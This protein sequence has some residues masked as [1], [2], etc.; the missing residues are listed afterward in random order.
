M[1]TIIDMIVTDPS[2]DPALRCILSSQQ[3]AV[4]ES[5]ARAAVFRRFEPDYK[6]LQYAHDDD[7]E[8][9][10]DRGWTWDQYG[11]WCKAP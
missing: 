3:Q 1:T 10:P 8:P 6:P 7:G 11:N 9:P 4:R 2:I 5:H